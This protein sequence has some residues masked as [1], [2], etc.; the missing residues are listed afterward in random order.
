MKI[1]FHEIDKILGSIRENIIR[2][3]ASLLARERGRRASIL[4]SLISRESG[5][6]PVFI[7]FALRDNNEFLDKNGRKW[8]LEGEEEGKLFF[9]QV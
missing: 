2:T 7:K 6:P 9:K 8:I 5:S 3:I 4:M 1:T